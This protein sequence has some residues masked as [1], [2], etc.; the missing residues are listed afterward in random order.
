MIDDECPVNGSS[1]R[2]YQILVKKAP[3]IDIQQP[4][5]LSCGK[6]QFMLADSSKADWSFGNTLYSNKSKVIHQF[7][8]TG[9]FHY[10]V[11][12]NNGV[13][14]GNHTDSVYVPEFIRV[15]LPK[16]TLICK[17]SKI[18][19]LANSSSSYPITK[20]KWSTGDSNM[21]ML[22]IT[23]VPK[24]TLIKVSVY[25]D[26]GCVAMDSIQIEVDNFR[27]RPFQLAP[28]CHGNEAIVY[29][30]PV[31]DRGT[32]IDSLKWIGLNCGCV[33][34]TQEIFKTYFAAPFA[35]VAY[36]ENGCM[37]T[38]TITTVVHPLPNIIS[39]LP[40]Q[41]C[42]HDQI[43]HLDSF[44]E[45]LGGLWTLQ[46]Q[47]GL[48]KS[49]L[50][51]SILDSGSYVLFYEITD[52]NNCFNEM[53]IGFKINELPEV[54]TKSFDSICSKTG[55]YI[56]YGLPTGGI[57]TGS[58]VSHSGS[59]F[60]VST[61]IIPVSGSQNYPLIYEF[62][63]SVGCSNQDTMNLTI[64]ETKD[65]SFP[66][67][68]G[69]EGDTVELLAT[70]LGGSWSGFGVSG[71][72]LYTSQTGIGDQKVYY[73]YDNLGCI[74]FDSVFINII[75]YP[76][77]T[78]VLS[79]NILSVMQGYANY[80]WYNNDTL[81]LGEDKYFIMLTTSG[82]YHCIITNK[83][84]CT[85]RTQKIAFSSISEFLQKDFSVYPNPVINGFLTIDVSKL[86]L[87]NF[88]LLIL[89]E[90]GKQIYFEEISNCPG[91]INRKIEFPA[92]GSYTVLVVS[93]GERYFKRIIV[94]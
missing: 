11:S 37:A 3:Q 93:G 73:S 27:V 87:S 48:L 39:S 5:Y 1:T 13:C 43:I 83:Y 18:K 47:A 24:D 69:C 44:I 88:N 68:E 28:V 55:D 19:L 94:K 64:T 74:A 79:K 17:G 89:D 75:P 92:A 46:G 16:D 7:T 30:N 52:S 14:S 65:I 77:D 51:L 2:E 60:Y 26:S 67:I 35:V 78:L 38:D 59:Q 84:G 8:D 34:G 12:K 23:S 33:K 42:N 22:A 85:T 56:L 21:T 10:S 40:K 66:T 81:L 57:W 45:P 90:L 54:S 82:N 25:N 53:Q 4:S 9:Y 32:K 58:I 63:D 49:K 36:N 61:D 70:P 76:D 91:K 20:I 29:T 41:L 15:D 50:D 31:F 71:N 86:N 72:K 6:F 62:T 80:Q